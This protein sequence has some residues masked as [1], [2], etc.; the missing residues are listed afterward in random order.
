MLQFSDEMT[1]ISVQLPNVSEDVPILVKS[2]RE[3]GDAKWIKDSSDPT[4][5][6]RMERGM[7]TGGFYDLKLA[8][9]QQCF[10]AS[11]P[12]VMRE[13]YFERYIVPRYRETPDLMS[14]ARVDSYWI[15]NNN[16][17]VQ[18]AFRW[19]TRLGKI[20]TRDSHGN[21]VFHH[22]KKQ[23]PAETHGWQ[24]MFFPKG[25]HFS[26][27]YGLANVLDNG[28]LVELAVQTNWVNLRPISEETI[29]ESNM[30][31]VDEIA[32]NPACNANLIRQWLE[33]AQFTSPSLAEV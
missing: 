25:V 4:T 29:L 11:N 22:V 9:M 17:R 12:L 31:E 26:L 27:Q 13:Q 33:N 2:T 7:V 1:G 16:G 19:I 28:V 5:A 30:P 23:K 6:D 10:D 18:Y 32:S 24:G 20:F 14:S 21:N 3:K 15:V 8:N